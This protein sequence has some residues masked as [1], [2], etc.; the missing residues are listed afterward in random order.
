MSHDPESHARFVSLV[1][2]H[3]A[4]I[5]RIVAVYAIDPADRDDLAQEILLQLWRSYPRFRGDSAFSTFLYR[6]ALNTAL[7]R[8]RSA[9][10]RPGVTD[11]A[12]DEVAAVVG[13]SRDEEV[14]L[15]YAAIRELDSID[16]AIVLLMLEGRR[17]DEIAA[18]TGLSVGAV[19]AR[20]SRSRDRLARR[21]SADSPNSRGGACATKN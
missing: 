1:E 17:Y 10:R 20:L 16:R 15:L 11:R 19:G 4:A 18:V 2:E 9:N 3:H 7:H 13:E 6:V 8:K 12:V 21:L 14:R 5:R